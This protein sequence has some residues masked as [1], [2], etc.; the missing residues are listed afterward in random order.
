MFD[1]ELIA[2]ILSQIDNAIEIV[3]TRFAPVGSINDF[4][5][6]PEGLE[7]WTAFV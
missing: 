2:E 7:N 4:L 6:T 5:D 1:R 3:L